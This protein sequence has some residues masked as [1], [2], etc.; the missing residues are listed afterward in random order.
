MLSFK[1]FGG[2]CEFCRR[3]EMKWIVKNCVG[4]LKKTKPNMYLC[5][6]IDVTCACFYI[7]LSGPVRLF[8]Q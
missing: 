2:C 3:D 4:R 8:G 6:S 5:V 1:C 7:L